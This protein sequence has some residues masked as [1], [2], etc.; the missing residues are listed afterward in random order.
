MS[1]RKTNDADVQQVVRWINYPTQEVT[2]IEMTKT[3]SE[4]DFLYAIDRLQTDQPK[5]RQDQVR[6]LYRNLRAERQ[7]TDARIAS[8]EANIQRH[9]EISKRL[10][11]LKK[12]HWSIVPN[13][14]ITVLISILTAIA[15]IAAFLALRH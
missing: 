1:K 15:V 12:P 11:D 2:L 6:E 7:V 5:E 3:W 14:W 9:N 8:E 4:A 13:F 10:D